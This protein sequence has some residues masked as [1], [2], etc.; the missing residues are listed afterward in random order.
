[1]VQERSA[2]VDNAGMGSRRWWPLGVAR[3]LSAPSAWWRYLLLA[4]VPIALAPVL[5]TSQWAQTGRAVGLGYAAAL[6]CFWRFRTRRGVPVAWLWIGAGLALNASGSIVESIYTVV[7]NSNASPTPA[8]ALYLCLY[9]CVTIGLLMVV[10][11][12]YPG[13]GLAKLIDAGT[14][15]VGLGLL[16]WVFLIRPAAAGASGSTLSHVVTIAYTVGDLMLLAIL[17]RVMAADGWRSPTVRLMSLGLLAFLLGDSA[18]AVVNNNNWSTSDFVDTLL[19]EPFL[20]AYSLL[21]A[22]A[23]HG[24]SNELSTAARDAGERISRVLLVSLTLASL[25]APGI[26]TEQAIRGHVTDGVA[27]AICSAQLTALVVARLSYLLRQ[28]QRQ[29]E[30]LLDL[31]LEDELTGLPNRRALQGY[32]AEALQRARRER[33]SVSLVMLDLDWFK[34]FNDEYGHLAGDHLLKSAASAWQKQIRATDMLARIGGEEFVLVLPDADAEQADAVIG[35]LR[36]DTPLAQTFSAGLVQWDGESLA[37]EL[38][39]AADGALYEAKRAGRNRT[40]RAVLPARA[41]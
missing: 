32:L 7:L 27:I 38:I 13:V 39:G 11:A 3:L 18:W 22:A 5:L 36:S 28:V 4:A 21:G 33:H 37:E 2:A 25:I 23:L 31:A 9:P 17:A 41:A 8:D 26:L 24:S 40:E 30:R 16:C 34:R 29:S 12:R 20:I 1:V 14:L 35:K 10:R 19:G 6:M 15:T